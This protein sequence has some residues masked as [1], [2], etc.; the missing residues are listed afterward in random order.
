MNV[1]FIPGLGADKKIFRN[2]KV[3]EELQTVYLDWI[4]PLKNES[5][6]DYAYRLAENIDTSKPFIIIGLSFGGMLAAEIVK[7]YPT[8]KMII[9]SSAPSSKMLPNYFRFAGKVG[10]HKLMPVSLL[11]SAALMKRLFTAETREQKAYLKRMIREVDASFIKWGIDAIVHWKGG[12]DSQQFVHIHGS[13]DE[14]L[15]IRYCKP[16][17][18]IRGGGHL[19]VLTRSDEIN[20]ILSEHLH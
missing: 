19:M 9:I 8:G 6:E 7:K 16:T 5:L 20:K 2:L 17:H 10:L 15:P 1:Y 4:S 14:L 3:P 13:G 18:I 11:K 12:I